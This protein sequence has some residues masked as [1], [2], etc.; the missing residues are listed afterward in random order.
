MIKGENG[1][2]QEYQKISVD[3]RAQMNNVQVISTN[4]FD[5]PVTDNE[6]S[7]VIQ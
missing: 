5:P 7:D 1:S 6:V 4:T 3:F 2:S